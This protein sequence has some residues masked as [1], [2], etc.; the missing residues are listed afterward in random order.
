MMTGNWPENQIDHI[1]G[2]THNNAFSNLRPATSQENNRNRRVSK[3]STSGIK[4]GVNYVKRENKWRA[5]ITVSYVTYY[6]GRFNTE[7]EAKKCREKYERDLFGEFF[8][9]EI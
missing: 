2:N 9:G 1:D 3:R 6:L 8:K 4:K 5:F 7:E